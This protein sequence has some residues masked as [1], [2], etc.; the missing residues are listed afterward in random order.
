MEETSSGVWTTCDRWRQ[1]SSGCFEG[2]GVVFVFSTTKTSPLVFGARILA[3]WY[4]DLVF[5]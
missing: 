3:T 2:W 5:S 1:G 4:D